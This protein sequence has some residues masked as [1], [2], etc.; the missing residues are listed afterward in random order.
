MHKLLA[1]QTKRLLGTDA[2]LLPTVLPAVLEELQGLATVAGLSPAAVQLLGNLGVFLERVDEAYAQSE[3]D[4]D[5]K[6]R[7]LELSSVELTRTNDRLRK[8]AETHLLHITN[9]VPGVVYR[10]E[11]SATHVR[12]TFVSERVMEIQ[13]FSREAL[14]SNGNLSAK[15]ILPQD[16][17]RCIQGVRNAAARRE[18]WSDEYRIQ[19][20]DG[21]V[22][23][24]RSEI[25]PE[26]V[27]AEDGATVFI[28]IW[29]DVTALKQAGA[30]LREVTDSVPIAVFQLHLSPQ[31]QQTIPFCSPAVLKICGV[32]REEAMANASAILARIHPDEQ[33]AL[34]HAFSSTAHNGQPW[35]LDFRLLHKTSGEVVWVHT[36]CQTVLEPDGGV[37]WNG[38][39][40]D[41]SEAK[42]ISEE[43]RH[44]KEGAE[45]ANRAKSNFLAAMSHEIRTPM[46]GVL[47]MID[48]ALETPLDTTQRDYLDTV[49]SS[50]QSLLTVINDILDF[51][52]IE[53]GKLLIE[54]IPFHLR[55]TVDKTI[56]SM[57]IRARMKGIPL[58]CEIDPHLPLCVLGD[59]GRLRQ[60]LVNLIGN[61][62]KFTEQGRIVVQIK[63]ADAL[64]AGDGQQHV[65][66][67]TI[68]DTGVGIPASKWDLIFDAFS[69]EDSSITRKYGGTG[70][71][72][73][74]SS[75]LVEA[76]AGRI[77]VESTVGLGSQFHF[78]I[79]LPP[80]T[81]A[82]T[83]AAN[84]QPA[85]NVLPGASLD[86][87]LVEDYVVN[88]KLAITLL[89]R[90]GHH[91]TLAE[92]GQLA[93]EALATHRFD[94]VLMDMMMPVMDGLE[95]TQRFRAQE[96]GPR[97]PIVAMTANAMQGDKEKCLA[98]GM[99]D[100]ISKP[101]EIPQLKLIL[102]RYAGRRSNP[103]VTAK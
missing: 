18:P 19:K 53:A 29:Q 3:R 75:R 44:A 57:A 80:S 87:L 41:I 28:G 101:F 1:R 13:G 68:N 47:G 55:Q 77:W 6:T 82:T 99:D 17:E 10:C 16:Q 7:S 4:L 94:L 63:A 85:A 42:R 84:A 103:P 98:S 65:L 54:K 58:V 9:A 20:P 97:T 23:W 86:V 46:N 51:S 83:T 32:T 30:R 45:S 72:L 89:T 40:A 36:E 12:Y 31:G 56:K 8:S 25:R 76:L 21:S 24:I 79:P 67:F 5:L 95:A 26:P 2:T 61:A 66:H 70:L 34:T 73:T 91:V 74:I 100:Y 50:A 93:L 90:W 14:M 43:L 78:L 96:Q 48:L 35:T 62:I 71:G 11:V 88:Q 38:Y 15:H 60:I 102:S 92:N 52:K 49:K 27:L 22:R 64:V 81:D 37:L 59:P 39:L 33:E 69:Q